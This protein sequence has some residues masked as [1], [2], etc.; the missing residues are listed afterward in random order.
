MREVGGW[1]K[2]RDRADPL[3]ARGAPRHEAF[4]EVNFTRVYDFAA[5]WNPD[6]VAAGHV[7]IEAKVDPGHAVRFEV[8]VLEYACLGNT[9]TTRQPKG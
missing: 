8:L 9:A 7:R 4:V 1:S 6:A 3:V 5:A 2:R